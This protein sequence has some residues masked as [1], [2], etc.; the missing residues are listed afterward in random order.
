MCCISMLQGVSLSS[1]F[2]AG[3]VGAG[4][5]GGP[6]WCQGHAQGG[7][8]GEEEGAT[9]HAVMLWDEDG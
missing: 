2:V 8:S 6:S 3:S 7:T 4:M 1:P 5:A 9:T